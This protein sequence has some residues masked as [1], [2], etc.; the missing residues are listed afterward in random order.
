MNN[1]VELVVPSKVEVKVK[2][3]KSSTKVVKAK[4][5]RKEKKFPKN[6][7][8]NQKTKPTPQDIKP[9]N[10]PTPEEEPETPDDQGPVSYFTL[11]YV[12]RS[13]SEEAFYNAYYNPI[14]VE[15]WCDLILY[16]NPN[17]KLKFYLTLKQ[18]TQLNFLTS[19]KINL[20]K[21]N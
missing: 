9:T 5:W 15:G 4:P 12:E 17:F 13:V 2:A 6:Q 8:I 7:R 10:Q 19:L 20:V 21:L 3:Y 11:G 18:N 16:K 1:N 14:P